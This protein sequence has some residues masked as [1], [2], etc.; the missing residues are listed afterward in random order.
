MHGYNLTTTRLAPTRGDR[1]RG[2]REEGVKGLETEVGRV[3][4]R[5]RERKGEGEREGQC[6]RLRLWCSTRPILLGKDR[7]D[8]W[9]YKKKRSAFYVRYQAGD[10]SK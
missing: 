6:V 2:G 8:F 1:G 7:G 9:E 4:R 5:E 3:A 10:C